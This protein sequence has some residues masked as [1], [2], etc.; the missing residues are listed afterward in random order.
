MHPME[1][2]GDD[3]DTWEP[4]TAAGAAEAVPGTR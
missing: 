1:L 2:F 3:W 4:G